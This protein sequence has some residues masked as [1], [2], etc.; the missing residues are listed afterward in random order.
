MSEQSIRAFVAERNAM[1]RALDLTIYRAFCEKHGAD[2][3]ST[4]EIAYASMHKAR[5][6]VTTFSDDEKQLSRDWLLTHG[7]KA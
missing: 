2:Q 7:F 3:E 6:V 5:L 4:D 1:L